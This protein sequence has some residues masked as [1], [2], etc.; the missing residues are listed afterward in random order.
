MT[1]CCRPLRGLCPGRPTILGFRSAP[2]QEPCQEELV[3]PRSERQPL[4]SICMGCR[5]AIYLMILYRPLRRL[6]D[7]NLT[8]WG[9][10]ALH[11]RLYAYVRSAH[12]CLRRTGESTILISKTLECHGTASNSKGMSHSEECGGIISPL[13]CQSSFRPGLPFLGHSDDGFL[14]TC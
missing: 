10:A 3:S 5:R 9:S 7:L 11:P 2:P 12:C 8:T 6:G 1:I 13:C 14:R 4:Q